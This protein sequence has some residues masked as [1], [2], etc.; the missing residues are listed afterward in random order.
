MLASTHYVTMNRKLQRFFRADVRVETNNSC[1]LRS[2]MDKQSFR[3]ELLDETKKSAVHSAA[4]GTRVS[5]SQPFLRY[6]QQSFHPSVPT[7]SSTHRQTDS[8]SF[9]KKPPMRQDKT[10]RQSAHAFGMTC[11]ITVPNPDQ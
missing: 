11:C 4:T 7:Y 5:H 10:K 1:H 3:A 6:A 2:L 8:S 9:A